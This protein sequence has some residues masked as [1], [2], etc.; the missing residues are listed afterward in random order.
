M[1]HKAFTV[2]LLIFP[3][4][5]QA[6]WETAFPSISAFIMPTTSLK[7]M[8]A[9]CSR[10]TPQNVTGAWQPTAEQ[11]TFLE[12]RLVT[13]LERR[14]KEAQ[15]VPPRTRSYHR[16]YIGI[17][18]NGKQLI[19]GNYYP[20]GEKPST[21]ASV[22]VLVCDGGAAFWGIVFDPTSGTFQ[23]PKFNGPR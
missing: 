22:P 20:F 2:A 14:E 19:Y 4:V 5:A 16:Q 6:G 1:F 10:S 15:A 21:E 7:D 12:N 23:E 17:V 11:I 3:L 13:Y 8:L 18:A 9:Q